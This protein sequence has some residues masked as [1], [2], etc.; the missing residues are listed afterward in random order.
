MSSKNPFEIRLEV[1]KMAK[2][3]LDYQYDQNANM[4]W[5]TAE[6]FAEATNQSVNQALEMTQ[7][8]FDARPKMYTPEEIIE[9]AS[10]LYSFVL[11]KD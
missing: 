7:E 1:L 6:K 9:K 3:M 8:L 10:E 2:E 4:W 11:K 5:N